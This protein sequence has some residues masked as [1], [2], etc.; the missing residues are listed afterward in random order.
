MFV[1]EVDGSLSGLSTGG[2]LSAYKHRHLFE[3]ALRYY[4]AC[5]A[6]ETSF[7]DLF[8]DLGKYVQNPEAR[9]KMC[10]R[11]KRGQSDTGKPGAC[12]KDQAYLSGA[13]KLLT[14][15]REF[16]MRLMYSG[17]VA[18][19]QLKQASRAPALTEHIT[20]PSFVTDTKGYQAVLDDVIRCNGLRVDEV[21]LIDDASGNE[22]T[23]IVSNREGPDEKIRKLDDKL[24]TLIEAYK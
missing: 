24:N 12:C 8:A 10:L 11:V 7:S 14:A 18:V 17:K 1:T 19:E 4:A 9:W 23:V 2:D 22:S 5:R 3:P 6:H 16:S 13:V 21:R 20:V 15:R